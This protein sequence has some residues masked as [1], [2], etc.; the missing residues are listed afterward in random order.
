MSQDCVNTWAKISVLTPQAR[1]LTGWREREGEAENFLHYPRIDLNTR[2][3]VERAV[4]HSLSEQKPD[5]FIIINPET[6][7]PCLPT[8][9][10]HF[11]APLE[12]LPFI[13]LVNVTKFN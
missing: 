10:E 13:Y 12:S 8:V 3:N 7:I 1:T 9:V 6:E 11:F 2:L 4:T 5:N